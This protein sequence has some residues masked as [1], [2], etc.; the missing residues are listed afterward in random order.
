MP[1]FLSLFSEVLPADNKIKNLKTYIEKYYPIFKR[2]DW[3]GIKH[4]AVFDTILGT[5]E[6][7]ELVIGFGIDTPDN[8]IFLTY[9]DSDKFDLKDVKKVAYSNI[10]KLDVNFTPSKLLDNKVLTASGY[11]LSNKAILS[12]EN[13]KKAHKLLNAK[14]I[15][16]SIPR[17]SGMMV[18][19]KDAP[20]ELFNKFLYLHEHAWNDDSYGNVIITNKLF[21]LQN[22]KIMDAVDLGL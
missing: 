4:G 5:D 18:I 19:S 3:T 10:D 16:V 2:G 11:I 15:L 17:R 1:G 13:M 21:L 7:P 8:Y 20:K 14:E 6:S 22:G 12:P 9:Q